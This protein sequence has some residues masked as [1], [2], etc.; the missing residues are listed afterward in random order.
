MSGAEARLRESSRD[1][2]LLDHEFAQ[3][4]LVAP[5]NDALDANACDAEAVVARLQDAVRDLT[6]LVRRQEAELSA[7][8]EQA[9]QFE[10]LR[11]IIAKNP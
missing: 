10:Q 11:K 3:H 2:R 9:Q 8:R 4:L 5:L 6:R 7:L 1:D